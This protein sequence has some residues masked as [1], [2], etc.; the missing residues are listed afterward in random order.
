MYGTEKEEQTFYQ[1]HLETRQ[2]GKNPTTLTVK[3]K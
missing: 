1:Q 3:K 2:H